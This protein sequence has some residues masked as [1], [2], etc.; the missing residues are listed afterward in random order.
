MTK[1]KMKKNTLVFLFV[2]LS[3]VPAQV[4]ASGRQ[5]VLAGSVELENDYDSN[6][7]ADHSGRTDE[8]NTMVAPELRLTTTGTADSLSLAYSPEFSYNHR[9]DDNELV[10]DLAVDANRSLSSH[11]TVG[12]NGSYTYYDNLVFESDAALSIERRFV[13]ADD[14]T[15]AE[16][17]RLLFPEL[18]WDPDVH[19]PYVISQIDQR[20]QQASASVQSRVDSLLTPTGGNSARQRYWES[21]VEISSV[22]EF[23]ENSSITVAYAHERFDNRTAQAQADRESH[24]PS[25]SV[26]Y[27]FSPQW[28]GEAGYEWTKEYFDTSPNSETHNP[29]LRLEYRVNPSV[30]LYWEHDYSHY[31]AGDTGNVDQTSTLGWDWAVDRHTSLESSLEANYL[32]DETFRDEREVTLNAG[33]NRLF[34]QG[35]LSFTAEGVYGEDK[36]GGAWWKQR[37]SWELTLDASRRLRRDV[38][39]T[40]DISYGEWQTWFDGQKTTYDRLELGGDITYTFMRWF[41]LTLEYHFKMFE[42]TSAGLDDF[43]EHTVTITL[44]AAKELMRW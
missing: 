8:W 17:V 22:Y 39:S 7:Y 35:S 20:Y 40:A 11:W 24:I 44:S 16:V 9:R 18:Q 6:I 38:T 31:D 25:I 37:R 21:E 34:D 14:A 3:G 30:S 19:M 41:A 23:A 1:R 2:L 10:H 43:N 26:A 27:Q 42:T 32:D 29:H 5:T 15:Q 4:S 13:R 28:R 12:L 33:L 36:R